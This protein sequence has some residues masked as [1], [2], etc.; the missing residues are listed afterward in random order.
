MTK[1]IVYR[2]DGTIPVS[3]LLCTTYQMRNFYLQFRDGYF[4]NLD[5]MNY[6]QHLAAVRMMK[7]GDVV[8]DVCCG[9]GLLLPMMRY[10]AKTIK[11]YIGVDIRQKNIIADHKHVCNGK[12]ID[13]H[14]FYPFNTQWVVSNVADMANKITDAIDLIIYT[15]SIEHMQKADGQKS[16]EQC[17]D[18]CKPGG[19]LFLSCPNTPEDQDGFDVQYRAHIYEWKLSELRVE[20][21]KNNFDII[22]EIGLVGNVRDFKKILQRFTPVTQRFFNQYLSYIPREFLTPFLF[23]NFPEQ[24]KEVLLICKKRDVEMSTGA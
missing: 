3:D 19:M 21:E 5:V 20:L 23:I 6:I 22:N 8:L 2:N 13:P 10:H 16:L 15:S 12:P 1:Q 11:K 14:T 7:P 24:S 4:T 9:R 17:A 18:V